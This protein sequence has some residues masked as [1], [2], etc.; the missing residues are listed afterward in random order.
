M[1]PHQSTYT[2]LPCHLPAA[3]GDREDVHSTSRI[4]YDY[5]AETPF[6][7]ECACSSGWDRIAV[8]DLPTISLYLPCY[9]AAGGDRGPMDQMPNDR[10][11]T[12]KQVYTKNTCIDTNCRRIRTAADWLWSALAST[13][14]TIRR[15]RLKRTAPP[16]S[17]G[18]GQIHQSHSTAP[19]KAKPARQSN[20]PIV[21][22]DRFAQSCRLPIR[23]AQGLPRRPVPYRTLAN[24]SPRVM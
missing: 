21:S 22:N 17:H 4:G 14:P 19:R 20:G 3:R 9:R 7:R 24:G 5:D 10:S 2:N 1:C 16:T 13:R 12:T 11:I 15:W 6:R 23:A 8:S 18:R